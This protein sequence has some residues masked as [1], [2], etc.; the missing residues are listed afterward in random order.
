[1]VVVLGRTLPP[2]PK[3]L[4]LAILHRT[5]T[6]NKNCSEHRKVTNSQFVTLFLT[7]VGMC[8]THLHAPIQG[9][10]IGVVF[11]IGDLLPSQHV[12]KQFLGRILYCILYTHMWLRRVFELTKRS[13]ATH[14]LHRNC[15]F[16][17]NL[18]FHIKRSP[19]LTLL[20]VILR[21]NHW[22]IVQKNTNN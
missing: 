3:F 1:M 2:V 21:I 6:V 14:I 12:Y 11:R 13:R 5:H 22:T 4:T 18:V 20:E 15:P 19:Q 16:L 8:N 9:N 17:R 7:K 10:R